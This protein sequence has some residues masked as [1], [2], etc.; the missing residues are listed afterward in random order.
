M[1]ID[2][3]RTLVH[4]DIELA[5]KANSSTVQEEFFLYA[6]ELLMRGEEFDD[7]VECSFEGLNR[8][9]GKM[10]IHGYSLD[11]TDGSCCIFIS[12]YHGPEQA[13]SIISKDINLAFKKIRLFVEEAT[14]RELYNEIKGCDQAVD[15]ARD[16]FYE[17]EDISKYR[18]YLL[19]DAY[20]QQKAKTMK[21]SKIG[22]KTVELNVWDISRLYDLVCSSMQKESVEIY[23]P[24]FGYEGIPCVKAVEY[25]NVVADIEV[26][27][28]YESGKE[29]S[30]DKNAN[31]VT[32]SSYLAVVPGQLLNDLYLE[33]GSK[34]LEGNVRSFLSVRGKV[35]KSIQSTIKNY[36]EMFFAYNNGIAATATEIET[37]STSEGLKISKIKDLQIVNGGQTTASIANTLLKAKKNE[38]IDI[39]RL[40]VPMKISVLDHEQAEKII[41]KISEYSNSQNKV[42]ASDFFSNH[43]FHIRMENYSR[44][45]AIPSVNGEQFQRY[46]FYERTRGQY[47]QGKMK[48][49][50][51]QLKQYS[52]RYPEKQVITMLDLSKYM[53]IYDCAPYVVSRGKQKTL[54][55]FAEKIKEEWQKSDTQFNTYYYKR[56]IA[57]AIMYRKTD[58][59]IKQTDW[60]KEKRSYKANVIAYTLSLIFHHIKTCQKGY[61]MDFLRIWNLQDIYEELEDQIRVLIE[62][63]YHFITGPRETENVTEWCKK[64]ACWSKAKSQIWTFRDSFICSLV[65]KEEIKQN[66]KEASSTR[67]LA[68]EID[69]LKEILARG[70]DYWQQVFQWGKEKKLLSDKE[71]SILQMLGNMNYTGR[72]PTNKQAKIVMQVRERLIEEGMPLQFK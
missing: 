31:R 58:E 32:Y 39:S 9:K 50:G 55:I 60:Y 37:I 65:S 16:L 36:P 19:T 13:A 33:Y 38:I 59:I 34:L 27:P 4:K 10:C 22:N 51:K 29:Q 6:A 12:D 3:Y 5:A 63:V 23:L 69:T 48:L 68:N 28:T 53:E 35:N 21:D 43:P 40:F 57:I 64:E 54:Q 17:S 56:V 47:N 25:E 1:N 66:I 72:I 30:S 70:V 44:K 24:D 7:F 45:N 41:P 15:F 26:I 11:E 20:N 14:S 18:F 52:D 46:W 8:R 62:E 2:E 61:E 67:K 42:D 71:A 49:K